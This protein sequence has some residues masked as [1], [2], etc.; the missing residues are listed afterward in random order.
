M[1]ETKLKP[2]TILSILIAILAT[3]ASAGWTSAKFLRSATA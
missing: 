1:P 3:T 2:V